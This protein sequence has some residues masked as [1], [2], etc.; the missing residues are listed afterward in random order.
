[1]SEYTKELLKQLSAVGRVSHRLMNMNKL[2]KKA[3]A[4]QLV[5]DILAKED[6]ITQGMLAEILDVRPSS[7]TELLNKLENRGEIKRVE[8]PNDKRIRQ[9]YITEEGLAK[10]SKTEHEQDRS[11][12]FFAGLSE[13]EQKELNQLLNKLEGGWA[14]DFDDFSSDYNTPFE[15]IESLKAARNQM[16]KEF[17]GIDL[18]NMSKKE[19]REKM[20]EM[21]DSLRREHGRMGFGA[22]GFDPRD[23]DPK[24][25]EQW[26]R[27]RR[28]SHDEDDHR[29]PRGPKDGDW[30][31][32]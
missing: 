27:D 15:A 17:M 8:D 24:K 29:D 30:E 14:E 19:R 28:S 6:G 1:M 9:V 25:F 31:N 10:V 32:W 22:R 12:E 13:E 20:R 26:S 21:R 16:A 3:P 4:Q 5:L 23:F 7:L 11:E 18:E 2:K